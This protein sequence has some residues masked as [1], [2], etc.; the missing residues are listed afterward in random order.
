MSIYLYTSF[1]DNQHRIQSNV[2]GEFGRNQTYPEKYELD[3]DAQISQAQ[4][5]VE[6]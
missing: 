3:H 2:H 6:I 5:Q 1:Y 4:I